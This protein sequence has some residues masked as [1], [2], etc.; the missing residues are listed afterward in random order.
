MQHAN[1]WKGDL[2]ERYKP[3]KESKSVPE[4]GHERAVDEDH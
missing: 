4:K 3:V 2:A 1:Y